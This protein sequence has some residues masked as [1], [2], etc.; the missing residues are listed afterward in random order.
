M[1]IEN[2]EKQRDLGQGVAIEEIPD[3][4]MLAGQFEGEDVLLLREGERIRAIGARCTHYHGPLAEGL[5]DGDKLYCPWH[6]ACFSTA[7]GEALCAPALDPLPRWR[8]QVVDRTVW[9]RER[10]V[11]G[12]GQG[13]RH[14][15]SGHRTPSRIVIAGGGAA[16]LAAAEMLRR[17][18]YQGRLT[19]LSADDYPPCDRPNLSKDYLA[20]SAEEAWIPLRPD[21]FYQTHAIDLKL[22][23]T[24]TAIDTGDRS[25]MTDD[26]QSHRYDALLLATGAE[27]APIAI[28]GA[29]A[30]Q[31]HYLRSFADSRLLVERALEAKRVVVI[32]T[33]FI[34]LEV[35]A[36]LRS[37]GLDVHVVGRDGLPL[38]Q[39]LGA[40][41]GRFIKELHEAHGV[42]F[43]LNTT[44]RA[45]AGK[46]IV[47]AD[48][49]ELE[50]DLLIA[51]T[52]VRP[53]ITLA[54]DAGIDTDDGVLVNEYLETNVPE[55][56][57]AGDIACW[58]YR[59]A[60]RRVRIEHWVVAQRQGQVAARNMLGA[61]QPFASAPFFWSRHYDSVIQY[62][63][64]ANRWD[65]IALDGSLEQHSCTLKY[66]RNGQLLAVATVGRDLENLRLEREL[67]K[68]IS[69]ERALPLV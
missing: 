47:L 17:E 4:G 60:G 61:Q 66:Q 27:P 58:P 15:R 13:Q 31:V 52:G 1:S 50:A 57:A 49:T 36:S 5:L 59:P 55:V 25:V 9:V 62:I 39:V 16:G 63:G 53:V 29:A 69:T 64:Y 40:Q 2:N 14:A 12:P 48:A 32:G 68:S 3:P 24:I 44:V 18:G 20:G 21:D 7:T 54:R 28:P 35:A 42:R 46:R 67:E 34:G 23:S 45:V 41:A 19:M 33:G 37:R 43:H 6:H 22:K 8:V 11:L 38:Q 30:G 10:I 51:G 26:G 56:Y 65:A